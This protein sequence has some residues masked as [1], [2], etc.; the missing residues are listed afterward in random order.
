MATHI[1]TNK[2]T[3]NIQNLL[4]IIFTYRFSYMFRQI[5]A[6]LKEKK[7]N[8]KHTA[9]ISNS[10]YRIKQVNNTV[11]IYLWFKILQQITVYNVCRLLCAQKHLV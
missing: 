3:Y 4:Q 7:K 9:H 6:I 1:K 2:C 8:Q 10:G 11:L 5:F